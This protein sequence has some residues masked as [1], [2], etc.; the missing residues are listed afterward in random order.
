MNASPDR[1]K[2]PLDEVIGRLSALHQ[3]RIDLGLERMHRLLDRLGHPERKLP[4]VIHI[5]GT[6]GKGSTLAYLRATLEASGLRVHAYTSPYLVRI[7]ECFRLGRVGGGVLVD[8]DELLA[9]LEEVERVNAGEP[10]TLFELKTAAAFQL[11]AQNPAEIVLLE[12]GLGGRLDS[13]NVVDQPAACVITPVSMDH[14]DF[15][16]DTLASIAGEKAAIIKRGVP[17]ICAE[18]MPEAMAVIEAQARRMRAPLFAAGESWHVNVE[19]GRLVYSDDRG[20]MDLPAPRLFGRHQFANAGLAIATLRALPDLKVNHAAFE[21]GIL[22]AEWPARMQRLTSGEL[23]SWGPQGS[24]IWLDGGH[25]AE[26]GRVAAAAV[27]DLEERVS[28]PLVI[29]AGMMANKD[30]QGFLANFAGLTRHIIA[31]PIPD[32]ENAMPVDRLVDAARSLGMRVE[33]APGV[34]AALRA[35]AQLAYELPPR[36]L[37]TG[38][39]YLAGHVLAINGT[40]PA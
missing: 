29:I 30:A 11:F 3:K 16:G 21:A 6:N 14:M 32:I 17:V 24:E 23:L 13:T 1:A 18:Q 8:G 40:P 7:N 34:E 28:R 26:G 10:A 5:A 35:L 36:I 37:I 4:P 15:L 31:V 33:P 39:L 20:L 2:T 9:A 27:G 22:S 38:S 19:R 12:V 25:N